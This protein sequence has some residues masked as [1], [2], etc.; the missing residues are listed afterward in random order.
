M[1]HG[2]DIYTE[3]VLKGKQLLDF[4]SNINPLG[5]PDSFTDNLQEAVEQ[6]NIYPDIQYRESKDYICNYLNKKANHSFTREDLVLGNGAGENIDI[7][8]ASLKSICIVVPSFVEYNN[9][10]EKKGLEI[11]YSYLGHNMEIDYKD[12]FKKIQK[13]DGLIIGNPNNPNGG[14][15]DLV[16]FKPI[17]DYCQAYNK[18]V[19]IDEAFIEFTGDLGDSVLDLT[20]NYSCLC[21]IRALTKFY[22]IPGVR[23]GYSICKDHHYNKL[24]RDKQIPWNINVFAQLALKYVLDDK[25]YIKKSLNWIERERESFVKRLK[26]LR[27]IEKVYPTNANFVLVKL[28]EKK[29]SQLQAKLMEEKILIRTCHNYKGLGDQYVRFAIKGKGDNKR[30]IK[31]L[32]KM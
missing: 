27:M 24:M 12:L 1:E 18:R 17:L 31:Q 30:L 15:I 32:G 4:S 5:V 22:G 28:N 20:N 16:K 13:V 29:G 8:I 6:M 3:G 7:A 11:E 19:I 21:V 25:D 2:G 26:A 9:S 10:A 23:F 14:L